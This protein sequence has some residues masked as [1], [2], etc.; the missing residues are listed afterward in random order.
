M[1][2]IGYFQLSPLLLGEE[3]GPLPILKRN[4]NSTTF[5]T[6]LC[7]TLQLSVLH[8]EALYQ[9]WSNSFLSPESSEKIRYRIFPSQSKAL[10]LANGKLENHSILKLN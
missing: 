5:L 2:K 9:V 8:P 7:Q 3:Q 4:P 1:D 10:E 6:L